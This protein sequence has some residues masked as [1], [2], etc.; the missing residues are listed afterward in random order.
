MITRQ[1]LIGMAWT[2]VIGP[3]VLRAED[4]TSFLS[5]GVK[6]HYTV[7]GQGE[8]VVLI[9]GFAV[10]NQVQWIGPGIL[11]PLARDYQVIA[12]ECRGHGGSGK[13]HDPKKYG[14]EMV[15]DVVRLLDH[16]KIKKA[17]VVGYSMGGYIA[18]R[19]LADHPDRLLTVTLG[20]A[21]WPRKIDKADA[22]S[23]EKV[24]ESLEQG[25]GLGPLI[26]RLTPPGQ[27]ATPEQIKLVNQFILKVL[28][29]DPKALAA[30]MHRFKD[31][32][33][34]DDKLKDNKVPVLALVGDRDP[35]KKHVDD[36]V[37]R[38]PHLKV[39]VIAGGTHV[40]ACFRPEFLRSLKEFLGQ[41]T[42]GEKGGKGA[43]IPAPAASRR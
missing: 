43:A 9:H 7:Q 22:E 30:V 14:T 3:A 36:M 27:P 20:G 35:L 29:N 38:L 12:M 11:K 16:L 37:G 42:V 23:L 19:L 17:H 25:N 34:P 32:Q 2:L 33:I 40:D 10:N 1:L 6:I 15:E 5:N 26:E 24:A 8:P 28:N 41:Q 13:P 21:G 39:V 4:K 31:L 18:V